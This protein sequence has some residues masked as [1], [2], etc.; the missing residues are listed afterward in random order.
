MAGPSDTITG[1][2]SSFTP[3]MRE[4]VVDQ[5]RTEVIPKLEQ[6]TGRTLDDDRHRAGPEGLG[7]PTRIGIRQ[8]IV[9][10]LWTIL[11]IVTWRL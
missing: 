9:S 7:Q 5:L 11:F 3:A 1:L 10:T 4:Y 2:A 6:V 8:L